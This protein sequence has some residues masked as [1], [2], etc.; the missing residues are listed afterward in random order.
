SSGI[1]NSPCVLTEGTYTLYITPPT[2]RSSELSSTISVTGTNGNL[3]HTAT[4]TLTVINPSVGGTVK[5]GTGAP[6]GGAVVYAYQGGAGG[7]CC[8]SAG[9]EA[10]DGSGNYSFLLPAGTS[11]LY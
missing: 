2:P 1:G 4:T 5:D 6:V 10:R 9:I 3:S 11:K 8:S 7:V